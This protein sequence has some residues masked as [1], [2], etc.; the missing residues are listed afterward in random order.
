MLEHLDDVDDILRGNLQGVE[1]IDEGGEF[2]LRPIAGHVER[3][4]L[5]R[6]LRAAGL[7]QPILVHHGDGAD[8]HV[9]TDNDRFLSLVDDDLGIGL[10]AS[11]ASVQEQS[12]ELCR[13]ILVERWDDDFN[14]HLVNGAGAF[15]AQVGLRVD[16]VGEVVR[17]LERGMVLVHDQHQFAVLDEFILEPRFHLQSL[18]D[19]AGLR[20]GEV[21]ERDLP[22]RQAV[23]CFV[24]R[25]RTAH[26]RE[27]QMP[28]RQTLGAHRADRA[29]QQIALLSAPRRHRGRDEDESDILYPFQVVQGDQTLG[30]GTQPVPHQL[31]ITSQGFHR[32]LVVPIPG[33]FQPPY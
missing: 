16:P 31:Q 13:I 20:T 23:H 29:I 12:G 1:G 33:P 22:L 11:D 19:S 32:L 28:S 5:A 6:R 27:Q 18:G 26:I 8:F 17:V 9:G 10:E 24:I 3:D 21:V 30:I 15:V 2:G 25:T 7:N 4:E 14:L